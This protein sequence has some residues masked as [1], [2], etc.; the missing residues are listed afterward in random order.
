M[1]LDG[2]GGLAQLELLHLIAFVKNTF[3]L[4]LV[5]RIFIVTIIISTWL[6][7]GEVLA[8]GRYLCRVVH[9]FR[10]NAVVIRG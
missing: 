1:R 9:A 8:E 2:Q 4:P 5:D 10:H 6:Y 3:Y 7:C